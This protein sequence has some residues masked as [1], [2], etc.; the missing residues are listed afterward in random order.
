MRKTIVAIALALV[1]LASASAFPS[2]DAFRTIWGVDV[3]GLLD[4]GL[5]GQVASPSLNFELG[6]DFIYPLSILR[7]LSFEPTAN[8]F[9]YNTEYTP[10]NQ[11]VPT[12]EE[13]ASAFTLG[14]ILDAPLVYSLDLGKDKALTLS[15]GLG[16][17][18]DA[19]V[20]FTINSNYEAANTSLIN[21]YY[22]DKG[23]FFTPS[24]LVRG[25]YRLT[26]RTSFGFAGRVYWPIY[27]LWSGDA[28]GFFDQANYMIDLTI[29][30]KL[31]QPK[32][33]PASAAP[34]QAAPANSGAGVPAPGA[35]AEGAAAGSD[36]ATPPV[37]SS[38]AAPAATP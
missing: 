24:T 33:A 14:L 27:N 30:F 8:L 28:Y 6:A 9:F 34:A 18:V 3:E 38:P 12:A 22:W 16:L 2:P 10:E 26:D 37:P 1:A 25:E 13:D 4:P 29:K 17:G 15:A 21:L 32:A 7:G 19:R 35:P 20:A 5:S 23:R 31:D 36:A 11:A